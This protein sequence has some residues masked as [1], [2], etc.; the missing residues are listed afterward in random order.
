MNFPN[1]LRALNSRNYR[2]FFSGQSLSLIGNWMTITTT[3][4]LGYE[5]SN[6]AFVLGLLGFASQIPTLLLSPFTGL[7]G[8]RFERRRL[9]VM[10]AALAMLQSLTLAVITHTG[11]VTVGWLLALAV[12][13]GLIN[14]VEFPTRQSFVI[15]MIDDRKDLPNA[16]GLNSSMFNLAR[17]LGPSLAGLALVNLGAAACYAIDTFTYLPVIGCLLAMRPRPRPARSGPVPAPL[18]L[19][20]AGWGYAIR[21]PSVRAPLILVSTIAMFGFAGNM[22]APVFARDVFHGD[23]GTLGW[24]FASVGGGALVAALVLSNLPSVRQLARWITRGGLFIAAGLIGLGLSPNLPCALASLAVTGLGTVFAMAGSNTL[25][26]SFVED[27]KRG[28]IMGLFV[29]AVSMGP[30]G[31]ALVGYAAEHA[32]GPRWTVLGC[33]LLVIAAALRFR[34]VMKTRPTVA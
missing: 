8:D 26:Q 22:L 1:S 18:A 27:D 3:A 28:R 24:M 33:S 10:L 12:V 19:L 21:T 5:L 9:L 7:L 32:A 6:S 34:H 2:L 16:I 25:I 13:Q 31:S 14:S 11:V 17:L 29:M 20:R 4:W 23:A 30:V 15:E